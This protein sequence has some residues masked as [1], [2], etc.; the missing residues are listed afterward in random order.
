MKLFDTFDSTKVTEP[1]SKGNPKLLTMFKS[2]GFDY[3]VA[4]EIIADISDLNEPILDLNG[5]STTYLYEA[6]Q[7][8][9]I[10]AVRF[11]LENGAD[12]N[13][14]I[15]ALIN[16]CPLNDLHFLWEEMQD[17]EQQRLDIVRLFFEFGANPDKL[18]EV[19]TLYD[20]VLWEV[21]NDS[22]T[23]HEW[24]YIKKFFLILIA[25][26]GGKEPSRYGLPKLTEPIDK[27]H[28]FEYDFI[29]VKCEDGYHLEGHVIAPDG[30]DIG[31]V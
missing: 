25:Y 10:E 14:D 11:L 19:E 27:D 4:R 20:H 1:Y 9:N 23:P 29:L 28:I 18:Y 7:Y 8:N 31:I 13:L 30:K 5:Y 15:P 16:D 2:K 17:E 22:I 6:E 3:A 12:P 21:F 26:G 24:G